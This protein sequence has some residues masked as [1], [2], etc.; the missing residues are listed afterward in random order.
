MMARLSTTL[1]VLGTLLGVG[2]GAED[3][4]PPSTYSTRLDSATYYTG[5]FADQMLLFPLWNINIRYRHPAAIEWWIAQTSWSVA[6]RT[7]VVEMDSVKIA[8]LSDDALR[9]VLIHEMAH[10]LSADMISVASEQDSALA[11]RFSEQFSSGMQRWPIWNRVCRMRT[12][13]DQ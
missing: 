9:Q 10:L 7:A 5:C 2:W 11:G 1:L 3:V 6:Y 8:K 4:G 13:G 12:G